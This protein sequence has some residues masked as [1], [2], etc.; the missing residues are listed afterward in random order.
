MITLILDVQVAHFCR[1]EDDKFDGFQM[2]NKLFL[3]NIDFYF[4]NYR[5]SRTIV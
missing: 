5:I 1:F 4:S 2:F 3:F